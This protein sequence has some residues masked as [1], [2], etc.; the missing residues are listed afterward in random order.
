MK[1]ARGLIRMP[2]EL[3]GTDPKTPVLLALSGGADSRFLLDVLAKRAERDGFS[4]LLAHVHHGIR[5]ETADRDCEFCASL[6][7]RYGLPIE[8][9]RADVPALAKASGRGLE[10]EARAVRYEFFARLMRERG[11]PLLATAHQADDLLETMLF[12]L[13]RGTGAAGLAAIAPVRPF[14]TGFL[15]R[16]LLQLTAAEIRAA[17]AADGLDYVNDETNA[18]PSYARNRIRREAVPA[19]ES[20]FPEPQKQAVRLSERL[21][22][23]EDYFAGVVRAFF[24]ENPSPSLSCEALGNLH[25]AVRSRVFSQWLSDAGYSADGALLARLDDLLAGANGRRASLSRR[26]YVAR[27]RGMLAIETREPA[28]APYRVPLS[29]GTVLLPC[30][31]TVTVGIADESTKIHNLST[32][33]ALFFSPDPAMIMNGFYWRER[34]DGDAILRGGHRRPLRRLWR[35]AEVS[36]ALRARLPVLCAPDGSIAWAPYVGFSDEKR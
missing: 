18:D 26:A 35:E 2:W 27:R 36:P 6:A 13:A 30:G 9:L 21:R 11:I 5:G 17:C 29:R 12:R 3:A 31:I 34:R 1:P 4:I 16:P 33:H 28:V 25:P 14:E 19:L 7:D 15:T 10:E 24:A 22:A 23:D 32:E 20:L 8:I